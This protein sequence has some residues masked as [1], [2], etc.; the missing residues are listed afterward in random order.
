MQRTDFQKGH[1]CAE[2]IDLIDGHPTGSVRVSFG[3][4]SDKSDAD[5]LL[6]MIK[7]CFLSLPVVVKV[8]DDW[9]SQSEKLMSKFRE[10]D[11][12]IPYSLYPSMKHNNKP[13]QKE[14]ITNQPQQTK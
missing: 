2:S 12:S 4:M 7:E 5:K 3:Y 13:K 9:H 1:N 10:I 14:D 6:N 11:A 8:P